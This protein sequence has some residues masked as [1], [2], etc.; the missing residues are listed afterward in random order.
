MTDP[1]PY[2]NPLI[3]RYAGHSM[4]ELWGPQRKHSTWRRLWLALAEAQAELGLT[5]DDGVTPRIA[6]EQLA[7]LRTH[8]DDIDFDRAAE[9]ERRLRHDVMAHIHTLGEVAPLGR[10]IVHLGATS[11]YVTDNT[12]LILMREGLGLIR[13]RLMGVVDELARF[14]ERWKDLPCLGYTHFQPAQPTTVGKRATLWCYEFVLDLREIEYRI[15][16]LRFR[17]AKGT[18]GTQASFLTLF[19]GDHKKVRDL[20]RKVA[21][22]MGF[23]KVEP[24]TGQTYSRKVDAQVVTALAGICTSAHK[25]ATDLRLLAHEGETEEPIEPEQVGSSAMA[26]KRNPMRAERIC[27]LARFV[28]GMPAIAVQTAANQWLERTLDD[29]ASRRLFLP[30]SFLGTDA[31]LRLVQNVVGGLEVH[32]AIIDANLRRELPYMN[33]EEWLMAAVA[34]GADR[35]EVHEAIRRHSRAAADAIKAGHPENTLVSRLKSEPSFADIDLE[36]SLDPSSFVGRA[37]HQV[38]E[39][40]DELITPL[41]NRQIG[42]VNQSDSPSV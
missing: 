38:K 11:C 20:D 14:A 18:T 41:R 2:D 5:A 22:K 42:G 31:V 17:G 30:Q 25:M 15:A 35:Q 21:A 32:P 6:P 39:F 4:V 27:S 8:L 23:Q 10:P 34:K 7:D 13:D 37:S 3:T 24:V 28:M 19:R 36:A 26:Y 9:H 33:T 29:S 40:L 1:L 12:D 16:D